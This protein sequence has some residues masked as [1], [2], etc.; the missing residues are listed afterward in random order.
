[1]FKVSELLKAT[2]GKLAAGKRDNTFKGVSI[3]SR[4]IKPKEIFIAL[5]GNNF[6]GHNFIEEAIKKGAGCVI[7]EHGKNK[8]PFRNIAIIEAKDTIRALGDIARFR[9]EKFDL[10][11][12]AVTGSN[13]KTTTKE[14]IAWVLSAKFKVL[15]NEG[16]K[17]N[18]IGLPMALLNLDS[19]FDMAVL[20]VG[21]NHFGEVGYLADICRA[22]IGVIT[23]IGPSHLEYFKDLRGVLKEK[24]SLL[25]HLKSPG[26]AILNNDDKLLHRE[27]TRKRKD[28]LI[29][30]TGIKKRSDFSASGIIRNPQFK[31][32]FIL[33]RKFRFA[34][35]T[36]GVYNIYNALS[37]VAAA[38][39]LG[40][41][42]RDIAYRLSAFNFPQ[43]R[44]S[45]IEINKVRFI[46]DTYNSNPVSLSFALEVLSGL[47]AKGRKIFVMGDM[48][49]LGGDAESFHRKIGRFAV[50]VCDV[51]IGVGRLSQSAVSE[52][53][54]S[55]FNTRNIFSCMS[56][57]EARDILY[58]KII[59]GSDDIVLVKGSRAMK[60]EE[61]FK[62]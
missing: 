10:P 7:C 56:N 17:N 53:K 54:E 1:M 41:E 42:Y 51:F 19:S 22:N 15:K 25:E 8:K 62:I 38:R 47:E 49:E 2:K 39:V 11:V 3:D 23:N 58:K 48:M 21:T 37:T 50:K 31:L 4:T 60:M 14:M 57:S 9:R 44:L 20:E 35:N 6:D 24:T 43:S 33:N 55:G 29:F 52:A 46:D 5:K 26:I 27:S 36:L 34:L 59:P 18:H 13:G 30:S 61:V 16:T 28:A 40:M 12:I 32:E 45:L